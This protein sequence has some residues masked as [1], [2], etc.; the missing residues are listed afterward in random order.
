MTSR[1]KVNDA[2]GFQFVRQEGEKD[3]ALRFWA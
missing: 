1:L 2:D 3:Q